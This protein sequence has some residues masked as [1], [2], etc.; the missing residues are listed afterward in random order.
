MKESK[1]FYILYYGNMLEHVD[2]WE[3]YNINIFSFFALF[4]KNTLLVTLTLVLLSNVFTE[5]S[6]PYFYKKTKQQ[7][8]HS[9]GV[10]TP[11]Q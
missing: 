4:D 10:D 7:I 2:F 1:I 9:G 5:H 3:M 11:E 8:T 6:F